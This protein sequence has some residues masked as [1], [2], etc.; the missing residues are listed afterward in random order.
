MTRVESSRNQAEKISAG[1]NP[2]WRYASV[3]IA[4]LNVGAATSWYIGTT[5]RA[6]Q[7]VRE[8]RSRCNMDGAFPSMIVPQARDLM[9]FVDAHNSHR[10]V[11]TLADIVEQL[12]RR[13][14]VDRVS[15]QVDGENWNANDFELVI[16]RCHRYSI[17]VDVYLATRGKRITCIP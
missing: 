13:D 17:F 14:R 5:I 4:I 8:I 9:V 16:E 15:I 2:L 12:G 1:V 11:H 7:I 6:K 10:D 3:A